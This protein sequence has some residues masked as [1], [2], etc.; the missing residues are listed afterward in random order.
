MFTL[1]QK[2]VGS[3]IIS[4]VFFSMLVFF[5]QNETKAE[6]P[7][8]YQQ[9]TINFIYRTFSDYPINKIAAESS[10][11]LIYCY[12]CSMTGIGF[13]IYIDSF[14]KFDDDVAINP[15]FW[16]QAE[17]TMLNDLLNNSTCIAPSDW[18]G[19]TNKTATFSYVKCWNKIHYDGTP[20]GQVTY[21]SC[22]GSATCNYVYKVCVVFDEN[23]SHLNEV[24]DH[25]FPW[26]GESCGLY[27]EPPNQLIPGYWE[28][29]CF[30]FDSD[31]PY[32]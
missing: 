22:E 23:G 11:Q 29:G 12:Y 20:I 3:F 30:M 9:G 24:F 14:T 1:K 21:K 5:Y 10:I 28:T 31:C 13:D 16:R 32:R 15:D 4:A 2:K 17:T 27:G 25:Q 7:A 19:W 6:C 26:P 18:N 8:G